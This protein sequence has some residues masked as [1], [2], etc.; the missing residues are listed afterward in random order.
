VNGTL[1][2]KMKLRITKEFK[3]Q[4]TDIGS[5][6]YTVGLRE[7]IVSFLSGMETDGSI[8]KNAENNLPAFMLNVGS[9][10]PVD[11]MSQI[12]LIDL[13]LRL[14]ESGGGGINYS[15]EVRFS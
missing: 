3:P 7:Q 13:S 1:K 14:A 8:V 6:P 11:F 12:F 10:Y 15:L 2:P 4:V 9:T 5:S